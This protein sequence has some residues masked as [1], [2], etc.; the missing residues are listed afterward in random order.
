MKTAY[1]ACADISLDALEYNI[2]QIRSKLEPD[3]RLMC[4]LK[5]NGY[6]HGSVVLAHELLEMGADSFAVATVEEGIEL[7]SNG[8]D[9]P[10]LILGYASRDQ[11]PDVITNKLTMTVFSYATAKDL[12]VA[13]NKLNMVADIDI[14]IDTGM[15]RI[16]F[17][18]NE[19]SVKSITMIDSLLK[20][21]KIKGIFTHFSCADCGEDDMTMRQADE[22]KRMISLLEDRGIKIPCRHCSN[23]ASIMRYPQLQMDM[24]RAGI[25]IYGLYPSGEVDKSLLD[26]K[27]VMSLKSHIVYIKTLKANTPISYGATYVCRR[28]SRIATV[29]I[30]YADGYPRAMSNRGRVL[31]NNN[32]YPIVGRICMDQ[33]MVDITDAANEI[34][35]GDEV[36]LIGSQ[37]AE[38]ISVEE[39]ADQC[40]SFNYEFICNINRRVP[41]VYSR[42]GRVVEIINYLSHS[43]S[44]GKYIV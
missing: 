44:S 30:G 10:I 6:G 42:N 1:R 13:A 8:I 39:V 21:V 20:N 12:D 19:D 32:S 38:S 15:S 3:T 18:V 25:I 17:K 29:S 27:P 31:I 37:G 34:K 26:L 24:V 22:F 33:L 43:S 36:I 23:S 4:V 35:Q 11:Y 7:R 5:A 28:D 14:K 2:A 40:G 9:A 16:G 41:R